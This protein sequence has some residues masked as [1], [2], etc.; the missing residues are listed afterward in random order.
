MWSLSARL[1]KAQPWCVVCTR[2]EHSII[3]VIV[4]DDRGKSVLAF[5]NIVDF[6]S[7][8]LAEALA[9]LSAA[10]IAIEYNYQFA[11][12]EGDCSAVF[13]DIK[14]SIHLVTWDVRCILLDCLPLLDKIIMWNLA[15]VPKTANSDAHNLAKWCSDSATY[16]S[17]P[18]SALPVSLVC[19]TIF[20]L[21]FVAFVAP[22][23][24]LLLYSRLP[25]NEYCFF[26]FF[27]F[28]WP[29]TGCSV[30]SSLKVLSLDV[31]TQRLAMLDHLQA[32]SCLFRVQSRLVMASTR[33][34]YKQFWL[35]KCKLKLLKGSLVQPS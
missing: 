20:V 25:F 14:D 4:H 17:I 2:D 22:V 23:F 10:W 27:F 29:F 1:A 24:G 19:K 21:T 13:W 33:L 6:V 31:I 9:L 34:P 30:A 8:T 26:F 5:G 18:V 15:M 11:T 16:G 3:F 35:S 7:L 28:L 12:F 32:L